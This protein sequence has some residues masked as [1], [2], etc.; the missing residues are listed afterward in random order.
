MV[1]RR[2]VSPANSMTKLRKPTCQSVY[3]RK[4]INKL[5]AGLGSARIVKSCDLGLENAAF[6]RPR[7]QF[8]TIRTSQ[9][10]NNIH[11]YLVYI[12]QVNSTFRARWLAITR[13]WLAK[14]Y[15]PLSSRRKR[16][17]LCQYIVTNKDSLW[18]A[19]YSACKVYTKT[20]IHLSVG[21]RW[22]S[23]RRPYGG[24]SWLQ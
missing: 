20:I 16:K 13:R 3:C 11:V 7:L 2:H 18:S 14:Y 17:W 21:D 10:A 8:F 22:D 24:P 15:S 23:F 1:R 4:K 6:S 12:T 5:F 19:S 9:P